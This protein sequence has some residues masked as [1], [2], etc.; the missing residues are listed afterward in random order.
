MFFLSYFHNNCANTGILDHEGRF[1]IPADELFNSLDMP[2]PVDMVNLIE[3]I[4]NTGIE[5]LKAAVNTNAVEKVSLDEVKILAP[6]P[7]PR[8][9]IMCLGKNY[10]DHINEVKSLTNV[11]SDIPKKPIY[12]SK[13]AYPAIGHLDSINSHPQSVSS[14]DY[15]AEL[16]VVIG[17]KCSYVEKEEAEDYIFGYT[18]G[19]DV[20]ARDVQM[21]HVQWHKGKSF[22]TFCPMGPY[23]LHKSAVPFP[24]QLDIRCYVNDELRQEGN[25]S[26]LIFDISTIISDLSKGITL[27]P[28]DIILTGTPAGVGAGFNPPRYLKQGDKIECHIEKIGSLI[29]Y[30]SR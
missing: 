29:N 12:F 11:N 24:V 18:I 8:R 2:A 10:L 25:T 5:K 16:A 15:E 13:I 21:G 27:Y 30:V 19:N 4:E 20:S 9:N 3:I 28:G 23:I 22:D 17:K 7:Y 6:I 26:R 14:L 1:V